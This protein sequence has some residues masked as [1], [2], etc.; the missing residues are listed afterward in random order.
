MKYKNLMVDI[1]TLGDTN[2]A[3]MVSIAAVAFDK[4]GDP[5]PALS[6]NIYLDDALKLGNVSASTLQWWAKED[7]TVFH[8]MLNNGYIK[9]ADALSELSVFSELCLD[10]N[11]KIWANGPDFDLKII[12][13]KIEKL[14]DYSVYKFWSPWNQR[15][16]RTVKAIDPTLA[17]SFI[18]NEKHNPLQ[19]CY[20]Q[21]AQ[22]KAIDEKY[23]LSLIS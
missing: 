20:T 17:K 10:D 16:V 7:R 5:G 11:F 6:Y 22:I 21:I 1:E 2:S 18:N 9:T 3:A 19:D 12:E 14:K 23:N 4:F 13:D 15:C 8:N